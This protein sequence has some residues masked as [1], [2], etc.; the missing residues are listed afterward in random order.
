M[1]DH[2]IEGWMTRRWQ[3]HDIWRLQYTP[4]LES[5]NKRGDRSTAEWFNVMVSR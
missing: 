5:L 3:H 2:D 1:G 4:L